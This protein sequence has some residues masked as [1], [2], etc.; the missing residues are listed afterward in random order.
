VNKLRRPS[1]AAVEA[2]GAAAR[3]EAASQPPAL[4]AWPSSVDALLKQL[5]CYAKYRVKFPELEIVLFGWTLS[6][7]EVDGVLDADDKLAAATALYSQ[8]INR[9]D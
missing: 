9:L 4:H 3:A 7:K 1:L 6:G 2:A 5:E 8:K